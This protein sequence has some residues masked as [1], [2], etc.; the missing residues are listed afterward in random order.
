MILQ[1]DLTKFAAC[2]ILNIDE[3]AFFWRTIAKK[4]LHFG[5]KATKNIVLKDRVTVM[6][7]ASMT[8]EKLPPLG[9]GKSAQPHNF[10][11]PVQE[12]YTNI[13]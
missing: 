10:R 11:A 8:G 13:L 3:T 9:I 2:D 1:Y 4:G 5:D 12:Q 7:G 6:L